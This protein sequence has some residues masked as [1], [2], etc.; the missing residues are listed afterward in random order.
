M[1]FQQRLEQVQKQVLTQAM[2]Q[3]LHCLQMPSVE[4]REFLQEAALSNPLLEVEDA[5][6]GGPQPEAMEPAPATDVPIERR[7]Q[8]IWDG[9]GAESDFTACLS[10]P[11]TFREYLN[12][13]LG[14]SVTLDER[15]LFLCRY[16]VGCLNSAGYLDCELSELAKEL[17]VPAAELEQALFAVQALDP[18][19]VGARSLSECLLLQLAQGRKFSE[20]NIHLIRF[21]LP[22]L[23]D[24]DYAGL[25]RL[26]SVRPAEARRAGDVVRALNPIPSRGFSSERPTAMI[27][28]EAVVRRSG[29]ALVIEM[30]ERLIPRV[31]LNRDYCALVGNPGCQEAQLYLKEKLTEAKNLMNNLDNRHETL[32]R[33]LSAIVRNQEGYFLRRE[34]LLPM[35]MG[36]IA[37]Q[38]SLNVST[39]SRA[40]K[41]KYIQFDSRVFPLRSLFSAALPTGGSAEAAR[42]QLRRFVEAESLEHPLSD[43]A[44]A[45]ALAGVG[46]TLSRRTVAKYR[47]ELSIPPAAQRR[48][49]A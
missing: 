28:P 35:T 22:L 8:L 21:G 1:A 48:R 27:A 19:G 9:R 16:L 45:Q 32:F 30:N 38:L 40:V 39:V 7:E 11:Q 6:H 4:L 15:M 23:A 20:V 29:G 42:R 25:A 41:D 44:L 46:L 33:L 37:E 2:L 17:D 49:K 18:P 5:P 47:S 3:S 24:S 26:L 14:Q 36:Q 34:D 43:E 13:Q 31:S 10:R 12:A